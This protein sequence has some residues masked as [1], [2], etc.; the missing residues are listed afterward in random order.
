[1]RDEDYDCY[2]DTPV[3]LALVHSDGE[4]GLSEAG[5][6]FRMLS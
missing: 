1:M 5:V 3:R 2:K 6:P 4:E